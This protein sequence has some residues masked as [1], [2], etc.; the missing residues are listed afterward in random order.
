MKKIILF[1][2]CFLGLVFYTS[3]QQFKNDLSRLG[4]KGKVQSMEERSY[5]AI[6]NFGK[7]EKGTRVKDNTDHVFNKSGNHLEQEIYNNNGSLN[8]RY[9]YRYNTSDQLI[10]QSLFNPGGSTKLKL[11]FKYDNKGNLAE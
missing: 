7:A 10:E 2:I 11:K 8:V 3:A 1:S 4:F 9:E 6:G 5:V